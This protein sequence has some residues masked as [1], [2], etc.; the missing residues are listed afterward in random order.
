MKKT[1]KQTKLKL[2]QA[3]MAES[4]LDVYDDL[5][6]GLAFCEMVVK[7]ALENNDLNYAC[8]HALKVDIYK[9]L[10][11][12]LT[13]GNLIVKINDVEYPLIFLYNVIPSGKDNEEE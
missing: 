9:A 11:E 7:N 13:S 6:N 3:I 5:N 8:E 4:L 12:L 10:I 1:K 2:T